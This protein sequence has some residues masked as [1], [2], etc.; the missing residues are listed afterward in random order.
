VK[1]PNNAVATNGVK[2]A[3]W[4]VFV[5]V[6]VCVI[7]HKVLLVLEDIFEVR[8]GARFVRYFLN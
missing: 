4:Q 7:K 5:R 1:I 2:L 3:V 8:N 6:F